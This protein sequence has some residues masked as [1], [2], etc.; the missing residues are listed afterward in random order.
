MLTVFGGALYGTSGSLASPYYPR[1]Y[2]NDVNYVWTVTVAMGLRVMVWFDRM[3]MEGPWRGNCAYD[4]VK[5][6]PL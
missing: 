4:Y 6:S 1:E 5:V 2:P 3:E